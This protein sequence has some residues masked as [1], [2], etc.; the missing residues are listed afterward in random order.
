MQTSYTKYW[1]R[2]VQFYL[3]HFSSLDKA[4]DEGLPYLRDKLFIS[5]LLLSFPVCVL[6]Y[7]ISIV[8]SIQT[9]QFL[10]GLSDTL[11]MLGFLY[12]FF[13]KSQ[14]ITRKKII[15]SSIFYILS[16]ILFIFMDVKGPSIIILLCTS[17]LIT[18][19]QSKRAGLISVALNAALFLFILA[20]LPIRSVNLTFFRE[21]P[22]SAW[23]GVGFNLIAFNTLVVLAV[24]SIVDQLNESFIK[25]RTLQSQLKR[26]SI[27]LMAAKL[28]AEE[29]DRLKSALLA[30]MSHEI[31][32]PMNGILGFSDLLRD[33]G[34]G[35][36]DQVEYLRI[37]RKSSTRM[38]NIINEIVEISRIESG[39][40]KVVYER[41]N[42]NK[43]IEKIYQLNQPK[44]E[45]KKIGFSFSL[46]LSEGEA[47]AETDPDKLNAVLTNLVKN[48]IKY[49]DEGSVEFGYILRP[50]DQA[51]R[52]EESALLEFFVRDT[53]IGI[54]Q[55][56]QKAIFDRF[57]QADVADVEARQG[58]GLG[59][60][61]AKYY[62]EMLK[63][64]I[65]VDSEPG[66]GSTF[67]FTHPCF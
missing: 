49:T 66:K 37:I 48:A 4:E 21:F 24:A 52:T 67:Y 15:F 62:V 43:L 18:L 38:L 13:V 44:A 58:A 50:A 31:R 8:V 29:S 30:N 56:R 23:F 51:G 36:E 17:V 6:A 42:I 1:D 35:R 46:S 25:E 7:I 32:T 26:E 54:P 45:A 10:I 14:S 53:G 27:E 22:L 39:E 11:A 55:E 40:I 59:L 2:Y 28:K 61:I 65:W 47:Q 33:P 9:K 5:V 3:D 12:I 60:S 63:G 16:V 64:R 20:A 57:I 19:F 34:L 41:A